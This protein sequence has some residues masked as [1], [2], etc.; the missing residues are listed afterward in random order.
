MLNAKHIFWA[1]FAVLLVFQGVLWRHAEFIDYALWADHVQCIVADDPCEFDIG[2][3]YGYPATPMLAPMLVMYTAF[4]VPPTSS[5]VVVMSLLISLL[6]ACITLLCYLLRPATLW[7]MGTLALLAVNRMY[8]HSNPPTILVVLFICILIL[9]T[10]YIYERRSERYAYIV[11]G[12]GAGLAAATRVDMSVLAIVMLLLALVPRLSWR[13]LGTMILIGIGTFILTN[14]YMWTMPVS[15]LFDLVHKVTF[16]YYDKMSSLFTIRDL[17]F[18]SPLG[19]GAFLASSAMVIRRSM[20]AVIPR[21]LL[22]LVM[23]W[24]VVMCS[25]VF[26]SHYQAKWY[27]YPMIIPW[28]ILGVLFLI[29]YL[30][31]IPSERINPVRY[32]YQI[33]PLLIGTIFI[34][35]VISTLNYFFALKLEWAFTY[36]LGWWKYF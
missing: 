5:I 36:Y 22:L 25:V 4:D 8:V 7:W 3:G 24:T 10:Q 20:P 28:E 11:W 27:F 21:T 34:A 19:V 16:H 13:R 9:L 1:A 26:S 15:H 29:T 18:M 12:I 32:R 14:P 17:I 6:G 35:N 23:V 2:R 30:P 31:Q 33:A